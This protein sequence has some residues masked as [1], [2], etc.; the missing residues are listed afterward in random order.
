ML[1][2][3]VLVVVACMCHFTTAMAYEPAPLKTPIPGISA[4]APAATATPVAPAASS[5]APPPEV[6]AAFE[7][8]ATEVVAER[9]EAQACLN[10]S[11]PLAR[12]PQRDWTE[13]VGLV[14]AAPQ[15]RVVVRDRSLCL[16]GLEHGVRYRLTLRAGVQAQDGRMLT[17]AADYDLDVPNRAPNLAFRQAGAPLPYLD[18]AGVVLRSVNV[19]QAQVRVQRLAEREAMEQVYLGRATQ[20][21]TERDGSDLLAR[22]GQEVWKDLLAL[23]AG[24]NTSHR[25]RLDI[26][27]RVPELGPGVYYVSAEAGEA[28]ASQ[29]FV[30]AR[31]G[32]TSFSGPEGLAVF[33]R[34]LNAAT[35]RTQVEVRLLARDRSELAR[36]TTDSE[37]VVQFPREVLGRGPGGGDE[38]M[39]LLLLARGS[40]NDFGFLDI[41][42]PQVRERENSAETG[43][44]AGA[45]LS[46]ML[47]LDRGLYRPGETVR[48]T[49]LLRDRRALA[50]SGKTLILKLTRPDALEA[51]QR[52][53]SEAGAGGYSAELVVPMVTMPGPWQ[54][55]VH[56]TADAPALGRAY[57]HVENMMPPRLGLALLA[58]SA[59]L[60]VGEMARLDVVL[61]DSAGLPVA[62]VPGE[63]SM[64]LRPAAQPYPHYPGYRFGLAQDDIAPQR[65]DLPGFT[66]DVQ[67]RAVVTLSLP[68][69]PVS[70]R[71]LEA[72]VR[73]SAFDAGGQ[74][75]VDELRLP[76]WHQPF[77]LGLKL[78]AEHDS[79]P[80]GGT[81]T[82]DIIAVS[83]DGQRIARQGLT[84]ELFEEEYDY[85]WFEAADG[86]W[87]YRRTVRD[88]RVTGGTL[89]IS[90]EGPARLDEAV[91]TGRY[92]LDVFDSASGVASSLR[93][94]AGWWVGTAAT[95][96]PDSV[97]VTVMEPYLQPGAVARIHVRPPQAGTV[98]LAVAEPAVRTLVVRQVPA[99]GAFID[100][101]VASEWTGAVPILATAFAAHDNGRDGRTSPAVGRAWLTVD[102]A[103]R[104]LSVELVVPPQTMPQRTVPV[105]VTVRGVE[106]GD[107]AY[108]TL[109]A[110]D[111]ALLRLTDHPLPAL[112]GLRLG[113]VPS[114]VAVTD[115]FGRLVVANIAA[116][117]ARPGGSLSDG[118]GTAGA[119]I[120]SGVPLP[121]RGS[122]VA[123]FSGVVTVGDDG[124]VSVPL[125]IPEFEGHLR[126]TALA[127]S[128]ERVG[129][130]VATLSVQDPVTADGNVPQGLT[131]GDEAWTTLILDNRNGPAGT[132][133]V[134][135][136]VQGPLQRMTADATTVERLEPGHSLAIPLTLRATGSGAGTLRVQVDGPDGFRRHQEWDIPVRAVQAAVAQVQT[137]MLA[138]EKPLTIPVERL[139][140]L[141]PQSAMLDMAVL[142]AAAPEF[143]VPELLAALDRPASDSSEVLISRLG[144]LLGVIPVAVD[145]KQLSEEQIRDRIQR[146]I[147]R[148]LARQRADG[149][150]AAWSPLDE[151]DPWLTAFAI[152]TLGRARTGGFKFAE[153][154]YR[155][156][157]DWLKKSIGRT[158]RD[159]AD[160]PAKAYALYVL[161]RAKQVDLTAVRYIRE[162]D[163]DG[164]PDTLAR[165]HI[166]GAF[167]ALGESS[168]ALEL[169]D[170]PKSAVDR[171]IT[172][173]SATTDKNAAGS[174]VASGVRQMAGILAIRAEQNL[175]GRDVWLATG[176]SLA[177]ALARSE[178]PGTPGVQDI[179]WVLR[180]IQALGPERSPLKLEL[181]GRSETS[182][183]ALYRR[184]R[185]DALPL[186][187]RNTGTAPVTVLSTAR[188]VPQTPLLPVSA[189]LTIS[190]RVFT[191]DGR[192]LDPQLL[193]AGTRLVV[194]LEGVAEHPEIRQIMVSDRLPGGTELDTVRLVDS[195]PLGDLYWLNQLSPARSVEFRGNH[196]SAVVDLSPFRRDF[197]LVYLARATVPGRYSV[198][199]TLV[200]DSAVPARFARGPV[201]SLEI[202][203]L[204]PSLRLPPAVER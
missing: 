96:R 149:A 73:A 79:V 37:G 108:L 111:E 125:A 189:G 169:L 129:S 80:E 166:A 176:R 122:L 24:R 23:P 133:T 156:G 142:P 101:P 172:D 128:A 14:P 83:P 120:S 175:G 31:L 17:R 55:S 97:A 51:S 139:D 118:G 5:A 61:R 117:E 94:S 32:L 201:L 40:N 153:A 4:P 66:T 63:V 127:W 6:P 186:T 121:S 197:R 45:A 145:L 158:W 15:V 77:A 8:V 102:P 7:V 200:E 182:D 67:G 150:F 151:A 87:D 74:A 162:T 135:S 99:E 170:K 43:I 137:D 69:K 88:R 155:L 92:R 159:D 136:T 95:E 148:V 109:M 59:S 204:M 34:D 98:V 103:P 181:Q 76:V 195:A 48:L 174:A 130:A 62:Q 203:P 154:P 64:L 202:N 70:S 160:R 93:F 100:L 84:Y 46:A 18:T 115:V 152:D 30:V 134:R 173:K 146:L 56:E 33:V 187:L 89:D 119:G 157:L 28:R 42:T 185:S 50:V 12:L 3:L 53:L 180:A 110:V 49:A 191:M 196:F 199:A 20:T 11:A 9:E 58:D 75:V 188:G 44:E 68:E 124:A 13:R 105:T 104:I 161:A 47:Y 21:F 25:T 29:W 194:V 39:P 123:L 164:L 144:G 113:P 71:P 141:V 167:A 90:A 131:D 114:P 91:T 183:T 78:A 86:R 190:R 143:N 198:P 163:W 179:A 165:A 138:P 22:T 38:K 41:G 171:A 177:V 126:V 168:I 81:A 65:R 35:P 106:A 36:G 147:E 112:P 57:F 10:F 193:V 1:R 16:E 116:A 85:A 178:A 72:R 140:G 52:T 2:A 107:R 60:K 27:A 132:Y 54:V 184:Y 26:R 192:P 19:P 82:F